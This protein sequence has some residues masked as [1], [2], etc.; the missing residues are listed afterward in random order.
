MTERAPTRWLKWLLL[1]AF[2]ACLNPHPD[3]LPTATSIEGNPG[4]QEPNQ[5][6]RGVAGEEGPPL[7]IGDDE[8][9]GTQTAPPPTEV[10][11]AGVPSTDA[12][13]TSAD[14]G[15]AVSH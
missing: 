8:G 13:V 9:D 6:P 1:A 5:S 14:A 7:L 11:D 15:P 12:G 10:A 3:E 4:D 2:A